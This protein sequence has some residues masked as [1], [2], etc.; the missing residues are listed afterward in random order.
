MIQ[1]RIVTE[2]SLNR[3]KAGSDLKKRFLDNFLDRVFGDYP[4]LAYVSALRANKLPPDVV[5]TVFLL[6]AGQYLQDPVRQ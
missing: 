6:N 2:L 1:L 4:G 5:V 3:P